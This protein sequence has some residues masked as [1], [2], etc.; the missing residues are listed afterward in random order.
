MPNNDPWEE[1]K[2]TKTLKKAKAQI[3]PNITK[4]EIIDVYHKMPV[5]GVHEGSL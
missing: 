5:K 3:F 4:E 2:R 1:L